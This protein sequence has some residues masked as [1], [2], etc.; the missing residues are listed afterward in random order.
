MGLERGAAIINFVV[1]TAALSS[2]NG[3]IFSS[4]RILYTLAQTN[5]APKIFSKIASNGIPLHASVSHHRLYFLSAAGLNYFAPAQAFE[6]LTSAVT[7]IGILV[8]LSIL[9]THAQF[10]S[11]AETSR[12]SMSFT[13]ICPF[14]LIRAYWSQ[15]FSS[16]SS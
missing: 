16:L 15:V 4:G 10:M 3:G 6:Y 11:H 9:F 5:H 1:I 13:L 2:C 7:F 14:G 12:A 8:W